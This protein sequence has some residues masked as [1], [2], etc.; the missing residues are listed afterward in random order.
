MSR[1]E[2]AIAQLQST[3]HSGSPSTPE[4]TRSSVANYPA[5]GAAGN[6]GGDSTRLDQLSHSVARRFDAIENGLVAALQGLN[7]IFALVIDRSNEIGARI[8][9]H[10]NVPVRAPD[11]EGTWYTTEQVA[12][13]LVREKVK[14]K[15]TA[16]TVQRW[17]RDER[18]KASKR[19]GRGKTGEWMI[20][21]GEY[22]RYCN[23]GLL[24][25]KH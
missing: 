5:E 1:I 18:I 10:Q 14:K 16:R 11:D 15:V 3:L 19:P 7:R 12:Q 6:G 8:D 20:S 21:H 2:T 17:C 22:V 4:P 9:E 23:K 13:K 24:P 25:A